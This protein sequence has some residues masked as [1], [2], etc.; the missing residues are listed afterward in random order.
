MKITLIYPRFKYENVS[1][2]QEP[3]G[4]LSIAAVLRKAN[5]SVSFYDLTFAKDLDILKNDIRNSD[6]VGFSCSSPLFGIAK[7]VLGYVKK[8]NPNIK[9][10]IGGPH[11]T[12][13]PEDALNAGFDFAVIGEGEITILELVKGLEEGAWERVKSIAYKEN[14]NVKINSPQAFIQ[15]L[16]TIPLIDRKLLDYSKYPSFGMLASRGC[17]FNCFY[18]KPMLDKLFGNCLR[19]RSIPNIVDEMEQL[20]KIGKNKVI[21]FR[22]DTFTISSSNW[23]KQFAGEIKKRRLR[24]KWGCNSRVDTVDRAKLE[25][26]KEA[27]CVGLS[28]GVESGS[29]KIIDFYNKKARIEQDIE[30][31]ALCRKLKLQALA[32]IMLGAPIE[33][34]DDLEMTYQL[35]RKINPDLWIVFITTPFPGNYLYEYAKK[36][37]IIRIDNYIEYDNAQNSK[38][39][40]LPMRLDYLSK[41]DIQEY[42][43]KI[44]HY[45]I[46]KTVIL[47]LRGILTQPSELRKLILEAPKAFNFLKM[48]VLRY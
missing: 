23:F 14:G 11:P 30:A 20:N 8:I 39:L 18:C 17:P 16:D 31:F 33:T 45:M 26:M 1:S 48:L 28:F 3:L 42:R 6:L 43:N 40:N 7:G 13:D 41:K 4:I 12:Q 37:N 25:L 5:Y 22:D 35:I 9:S 10:I 34:R 2:I 44:N 19:I 29:Q 32:F 47:R 38:D 15:D 21:Y 27:G 46:R 36:R 24:I